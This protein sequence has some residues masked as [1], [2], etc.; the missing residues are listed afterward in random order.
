MA[1]SYFL[2]DRSHDAG[3][4]RMRKACAII[5]KICVRSGK[6]LCLWG[7]DERRQY[8]NMWIK[9]NDDQ[10]LALIYLVACGLHMKHVM[11][12]INE[13]IHLSKGKWN[14]D[15]LFGLLHGCRFR[16][17]E[18][19]FPTVVWHFHEGIIDLLKDSP[20]GGTIVRYK[21]DRKCVTSKGFSW[22]GVPALCMSYD[23]SSMSF[24]AG[25]LASGKLLEKDGVV[26]I[27]YRATLRNWFVKVGI[28]LE[29]DD[30]RKC[31]ISPVWPALF[32]IH[33]PGICKRKWR[34]I[35]NA[36]GAQ[37]YP[38]ILWFLYKDMNFISGGIP[39]L[40]CRRAVFYDFQCKEGAK[41][42]LMRLFVELGLTGMDKRI[43]DCVRLWTKRAENCQNRS[44]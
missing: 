10:P 44:E 20:Y 5:A 37:L 29:S 11:K 39:Y 6:S 25:V 12:E 33:M 17:G 36:C 28:P 19:H 26:Y 27:K 41:K 23:E 7:E 4:I 16:C 2:I 13:N 40:R 22:R 9:E 8:H 34:D 21:N 24:M 31:L 18:N 15:F 3:A 1:K 42:K 38:P 14:S 32:S 43:G 30:K 35:K